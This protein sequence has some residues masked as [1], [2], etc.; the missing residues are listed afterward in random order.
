[1]VFTGT[2]AHCT[3]KC[4]IYLNA[5]KSILNKHILEA[6]EM[7]LKK[8]THPIDIIHNYPRADRELCVF[9]LG[10]GSWFSDITWSVRIFSNATSGSSRRWSFKE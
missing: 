3:D 10:V 5:A 7:I 2:K 6:H 4:L 1:M 8:I 9:W